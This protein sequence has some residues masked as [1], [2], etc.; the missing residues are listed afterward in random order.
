MANATLKAGKWWGM[1]SWSQA[2]TRR[3]LSRGARMVT[4]ANDHTVLVKGFEGAFKEVSQI[5]RNEGDE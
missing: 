3:A 5:G 1:P 2:M 4:A